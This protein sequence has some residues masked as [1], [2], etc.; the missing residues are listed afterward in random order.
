MTLTL[1]RTVDR[2]SSR[3]NVRLPSVSRTINRQ[4]LAE[5]IGTGFVGCDSTR[6]PVT[7]NR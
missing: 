6:T 7:R 4:E 5:V 3:S 1:S 2:D